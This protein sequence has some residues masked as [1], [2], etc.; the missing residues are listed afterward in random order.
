MTKYPHVLVVYIDDHFLE[1]AN[2][3]QLD[4][5]LKWMRLDEHHPMWEFNPIQLTEP[6]DGPDGDF[7]RSIID[8]RPELLLLELPSLES[9]SMNLIHLLKTS[10]ATRRIPIIAIG[11]SNGDLELALQAGADDAFLED[12]WLSRS[13]NMFTS[14]SARLAVKDSNQACHG[15]LHPLAAEG[16]SAINLGQYYRAHELL[17]E[18][19]MAVEEGEGRLYRALLQIAVAYLQ[20]QRQNWR[21][22]MKMLLRMRQWLD[23]LPPVCMGIDIAETQRIMANLRDKLDKKLSGRSEVMDQ[24]WFVEIPTTSH[25]PRSDSA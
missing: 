4:L 11:K 6:L 2:R 3:L 8:D 23:P 14:W 15:E 19:W 24:E 18:A 9:P 20:I 5:K 10:A 12:D 25:K 17:E 21:G 22:A 13:K 7:M 16:I 1:A